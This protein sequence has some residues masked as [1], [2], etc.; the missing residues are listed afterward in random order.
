MDLM[1]AAVGLDRSRDR[2]QRIRKRT[3]DRNGPIRA[4]QRARK[5]DVGLQ[6]L[7]ERQHIGPAP[8]GSAVRR[9]VIVIVGRA[10]QRD[11][12]HHR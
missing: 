7:E 6:L 10:A 4:V 3:T 11:H 9:P 8:P 2:R 12:S 1:I 5:I